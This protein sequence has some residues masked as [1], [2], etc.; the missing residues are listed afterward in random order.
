MTRAG[1]AGTGD[2]ITYRQEEQRPGRLLKNAVYVAVSLMTAPVVI[3]LLT[4]QAAGCGQ[5]ESGC[6]IV[7][8]LAVLGL[9]S[10]VLVFLV[11]VVGPRGPFRRLWRD[12]V[13]ISVDREGV[14]WTEDGHPRRVSWNEVGGFAEVLDAP[15]DRDGA[16]LAL[17]GKELGRV[18][19]RVIGP[20]GRHEWTDDV[21]GEA[22][23]RFDPSRFVRGLRRP[24]GAP[25]MLPP[26]DPR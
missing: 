22:L 7:G 20:D 21:L 15:R 1:P 11:S 18:P 9:F 8:G 16:I 12:P 10:L 23:F 25:P 5:S 3:L 13:T 26:A 14:T 17:D 19:N 24:D 6:A 2:T 4:N